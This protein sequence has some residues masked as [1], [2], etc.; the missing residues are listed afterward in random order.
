VLRHAIVAEGSLKHTLILMFL[1]KVPYAIVCCTYLMSRQL[2]DEVLEYHPYAFDARK[3]HF[4]NK[5]VSALAVQRS[6][7]G[8]SFLSVRTKRHRRLS[9]SDMF[10]PKDFHLTVASNFC[11]FVRAQLGKGAHHIRHYPQRCEVFEVQLRE[12]QCFAT[13]RYCIRTD[14]YTLK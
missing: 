11:V 13:A 5:S 6:K 7:G 3:P 8:I 14:A 4:N 2:L 9:Y 12:G 10:N 1:F